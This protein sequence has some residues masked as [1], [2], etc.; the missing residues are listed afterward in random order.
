MK[1]IKLLAFVICFTNIVN[2]QK[3]TIVKQDYKKALAIASKENKLILVDFYTTWC[4]PCKELDE[5]V[6]KKNSIKKALA[7]DFVLLKYNAED[8]KVFNLSKKHH[9]MSYPTGVILNKEGYLIHRK[10]G[11]PGDDAETLSKSVLAFTN[12]AVDFHKKNEIVKGYTNTI[13]ISK[14]PKFY[15]DYINRDSKK[16]DT[17]QFNTYLK[18]ER[19]ILSEEYFSVLFYFAR[20]IPKK[21][22]DSAFKNRQ[23]YL[24][25]FGK[26]DTDILFYFLGSSKFESA[27][28]NNSKRE[29]NE[30]V[31][32]IKN[33][34]DEKWANSVISSYQKRFLMAQNKWEEVF[35]INESLK[36]KGKFSDGAVN[37][38]CWTVYKECNDKKVISKCINWMREITQKTPSYAYLDTYAFL[39]FKSGDKAEAKRVAKLAIEKGKQEKESTKSLENL[40]SK[41]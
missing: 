32:F 10:Y 31:N 28:T 29:F 30:A 3:L 15:I 14:Y 24:N 5:L 33:C 18:T 25:L 11:F 20:K 19:N 41:V 4:K 9:V 37:H 7:K 16:L 13:D 1:L 38:F 2:A 22:A 26:L 21:V 40:L 6:L 12:E 17:E 23:K 8:D 36:V 27:I 35:K 39:L 34:L